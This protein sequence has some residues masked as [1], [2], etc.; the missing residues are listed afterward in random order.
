MHRPASVVPRAVFDDRLLTAALASGAEFRRHIVRRIDGPTRTHVEV[1]GVLEA[2]V[3]VGADGAESVVR[4]ALGIRAE[5]PDD[6]AGRSRS[7]A[8]R[9]SRPG[10]PASR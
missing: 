10:R 6:T 1:D 4:R 7:A 3:V 5:P 9:P 2:G 8:T